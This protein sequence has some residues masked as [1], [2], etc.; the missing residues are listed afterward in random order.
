MRAIV[1]GAGIGGIAAA[2]RTARLGY[3]VD[4][5]E[6]SVGPGGKLSS[7]QL[8]GFRFDRGPSLFTMPQYVD[9][10]F[11][12]CEEDPR[13]HFDYRR[14]EVVCRYFWPSGEQL[15]AYA[16]PAL[17][18]AEAAKVF[19]VDSNLV[20][21]AL[22]ASSNKYELAGRTFLERP[23]HKLATWTDPSVRRA[24][25]QLAN[26]DLTRT[27]HA[28][29][30]RDLGHPKLVQLFDRFATYN[31]SNPYRAP[32][33]LTII[34]TFEHLLGTFLPK[35]G[36]YD[37]TRQLALLA[38][39]QGVRFHFNSRV[40]RILS[41]PLGRRSQ[42]GR[43]TGIELPDGR[44]EAC[45]LLV[46]NAD[47]HGF[48]QQLMPQARKPWLTLRQERSTS[49]VIFYWGVRGDFSE[50]GLHNIFFCADY[51]AE[52]EALQT[53]NIAD[54]F[55]I[56][57][58]VTSKGVEREAPPGCENWFVM[59]NAPYQRGQDWPT[60][61][62]RLRA[63]IIQRLSAKL[64]V[65]LAEHIVVEHTWTPPEIDTDTGSH[66]GALYGTSSNSR[67]AAFLRHR[68]ESR[69]FENLYFVGGSVHPGGGVPLALLSARITSG[70]IPPAA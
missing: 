64:A 61:L 26:M 41:E 56:Y 53:G 29:N 70:L 18:S 33:I 2:I 19:G 55:T 67:W 15:V 22:A 17:F 69:E 54:D 65:N 60:I 37:I 23:L 32:G 31:G 40:K 39:R 28:A 10:L 51:Q 49:A 57:V 34:P 20:S 11:E 68:N 44:V 1:V 5:F 8:E 50:L 43:V 24:L 9:E 48:Y 7:F 46:S 63:A 62:I 36:M 27:M 58:N 66:L 6:G 25:P 4:V 52:F 3:Q 59:V 16:D 21:R 13:A 47:V 38:E 14:E 42:S 30:V 45:D 12:L 35:G